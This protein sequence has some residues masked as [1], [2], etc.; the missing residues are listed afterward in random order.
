[1]GG[2]IQVAGA[3]EESECQKNQTEICYFFHMIK[4]IYFQMCHMQLAISHPLV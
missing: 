4:A 3:E 2:G 1:L